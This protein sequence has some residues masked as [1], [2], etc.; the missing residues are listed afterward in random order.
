L[1]IIDTAQGSF[2]FDLELPPPVTD[3]A[4]IPLPIPG[5]A[6]DPYARA[7]ERTF[8]LIKDAASS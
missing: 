8:E 1:R 4:Q 6:L 2:G 3:P 5:E 7:I